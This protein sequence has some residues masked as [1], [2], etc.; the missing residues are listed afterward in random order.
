MWFDFGAHL[1]LKEVIVGSQFNP[2]NG[3]RLNDVLKKFTDVEC[4]WAYMR[5]DAFLLV[6]SPV[7]QSTT[8]RL[9]GIRRISG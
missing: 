3:D 2:R 4:T 1:D 8:F 9:K 6:K 7:P 5:S